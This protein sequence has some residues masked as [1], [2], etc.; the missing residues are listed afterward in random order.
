MQKKMPAKMRTATRAQPMATPVVVE[1][2]IPAAAA[3]LDL[4]SLSACGANV[5]G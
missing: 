2:D 3:L 4:A 5:V 1:L